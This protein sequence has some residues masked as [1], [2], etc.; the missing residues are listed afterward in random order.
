MVAAVMEGSRP[1]L[2]EVQALTAF[3]KMTSP[4]R[5]VVGAD[6]NRA[7]IV[8]AVLEKRAEIKTAALDVFINIAGGIR[9]GEP[10]IDL[11]MALSVASSY[12]NRP[13]AGD[14]ACA[15]EI[16]LA[17][18]IRA[19]SQVEARVREGAKLGFTKGVIPSNNA[20]KIERVDGI[21]LI[22]VSSVDEALEVLIS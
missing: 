16:G 4:R 6:Y 20:N 7:I 3:T 21:E 17:G 10:A 11:P 14:V 5:T 12:K 22:G 2:L 19:I 1:L 15:G 13:I 8:L 9:A 18:E